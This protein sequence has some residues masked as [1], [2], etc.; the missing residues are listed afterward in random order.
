V[1]R[2]RIWSSGKT[3]TWVLPAKRRKALECKIAV[4]VAL[5]AGAE[6]IGRLLADSITRAARARGALGEQ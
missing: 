6:F 4:A 1:R 5:E 3:K 2:V